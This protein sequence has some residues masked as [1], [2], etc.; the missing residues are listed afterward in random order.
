MSLFEIIKSYLFS[1]KSKEKYKYRWNKF[2]P[3]GSYNRLYLKLES[4][5]SCLISLHK[6]HLST[7]NQRFRDTSINLVGTMF[8]GGGGKGETF[9]IEEQLIDRGKQN[10]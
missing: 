3:I 1:A 8:K 2:L 10:E 9:R 5:L 4:V 6:A 7:F